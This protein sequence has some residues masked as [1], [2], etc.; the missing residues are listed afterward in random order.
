MTGTLKN[1]RLDKK[2]DELSKKNEHALICYVVAGYPDVA[3]TEDII[4]S[5][6]L[7][8][9]DIIEIG[10]PFS[11]PIADGSVIEEASHQALLS[12]I[13]PEKCLNI[14]QNIRSKFPDL[15]ILIMT[16][17]NILLKAGFKNFMRRS[18]HSGIDGFILPDM[19]IEQSCCYIEQASKLGLATVFLVSPNTPQMRLKTIVSKCSGFVYAVSVYGIT[20]VRE[21]FEEYTLDAIRNIKEATGSKIPVAV[22]FG[23]SRTSHIKSMVDAGADA[24]IIGSAIVKKIKSRANKRK[25][26][27]HLRSYTLNMKKACK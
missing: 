14:S 25:M 2:F 17:S 1:N 5:L 22:G 11:D 16:Y 7:S 23:I 10:I 19:E 26:L 24:V 13:T 9:A 3:T 4:S 15:P 21:S 18:K 20:G 8:G 12:G 27:Q 6:V